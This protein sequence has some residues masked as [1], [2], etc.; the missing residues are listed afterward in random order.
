MI[1]NINRKLADKLCSMA[2]NNENISFDIDSK[3]GNLTINIKKDFKNRQNYNIKVLILKENIPYLEIY[4][5]VWTA[6]CIGGNSYGEIVYQEPNEK[7]PNG[8]M[9]KHDFYHEDENY[10]TCEKCGLLHFN[11]KEFYV[12]NNCFSISDNCLINKIDNSCYIGISYEDNKYIKFL[13]FNDNKLIINNKDSFKDIIFN[14]I[15]NLE[16]NIKITKKRSNYDDY[17]I[18]LID[19]IKE[20]INEYLDIEK[21]DK[22]DKQLIKIYNMYNLY[23]SRINYYHD[24]EVIES[25]L[26]NLYMKDKKES[27]DNIVLKKR[28]KLKNISFS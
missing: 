27:K 9:L 16:Q 2:K 25:I 17:S 10:I 12:N 7:F 15:K 20:K 1:K 21:I 11:K 5:N 22:I 14:T 19:I 3:I 6:E 18:Q 28:Y 8:Y 13:K 24:S 4:K 23:K 26:N